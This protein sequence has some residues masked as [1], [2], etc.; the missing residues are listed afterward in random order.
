MKCPLK[1]QYPQVNAIPEEFSE[2]NN[3]CQGCRNFEYCL[4]GELN[5]GDNDMEKSNM[6]SGD[7]FPTYNIL[8]NKLA[9]NKNRKEMVEKLLKEDF[10]CI[11][12]DDIFDIGLDIEL[13]NKQC[14]KEKIKKQYQKRTD[15]NGN[16]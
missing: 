16:I 3:V 2:W 9:L 11:T 4:N 6:A 13:Y 15:I 12:K 8:H 1:K 14:R 5:E 7:N 10:G